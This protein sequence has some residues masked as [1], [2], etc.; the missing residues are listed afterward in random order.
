MTP[1][2]D[3]DE[4]PFGKYQGHKMSD[5]PASYFHWLWTNDKDPMSKWKVKVDPVAD[6]IW[7]N[8]A[9]LMKEHPD[10]IWD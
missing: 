6:Y 4:M 10:G 1:L 3:D 8:M 7:R 2:Q 9:G 5:V